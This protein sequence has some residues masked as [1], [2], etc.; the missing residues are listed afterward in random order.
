MVLNLRN[1]MDG[2]L[3]IVGAP[4]I[5]SKSTCIAIV[6]KPIIFFVEYLKADVKRNTTDNI[7]MKLQDFMR[8]RNEKMGFRCC[9]SFLSDSC[10]TMRYVRK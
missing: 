7:I 8:K 10:N 5:V 4:I 1:F 3:G 2:T 6:Q 9:K